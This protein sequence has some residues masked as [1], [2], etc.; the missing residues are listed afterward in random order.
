MDPLLLSQHISIPKYQ[1]PTARIILYFEFPVAIG[2][3]T[4]EERISYQTTHIHHAILIHREETKI[5]EE[6][7]HPSKA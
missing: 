7:D 5:K 6:K 1:L 2:I 4:I 3:R